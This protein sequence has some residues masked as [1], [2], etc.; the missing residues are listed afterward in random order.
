MFAQ[1]SD[2]FDDGDFTHNPVW[3]GTNTL[4]TVTAG[5]L[6]LSA[7][8][9]SDMAYLSTQSAAL[10]DATWEA[11]VWL[12]FNASATNY[13]RFYLAS[14]QPT[15][16]AA[17]T[18]YFVQIGGATDDV[19]LFRQEGLTLE[20]LIDGADGRL[21]LASVHVKIKVTRDDSGVWQLFSDVNNG[22]LTLEGTKTDVTTLTSNYTGLSCTFTATRSDKFAFDNFRVTGHAVTDKT[23]PALSSIMVLSSTRLAVLFSE[24]LEQASAENTA[25]Y[26]VGSNS[27]APVSATLLADQKTVELLFANAFVNGVATTLGVQGVRDLAGNAMA[28]AVRDFTYLAPA[29]ATFKDLLI[30]EIF[31][32]PS[33]KIRLPEAEYVEV[34][35]RS[36]TPFSLKNWRLTDGSTAATL[37]EFILLPGDFAVLTSA[38]TGFTEVHNALFI[39]NFPTLNNGSDFVVLKDERGVTIDS[40][41]YLADWFGDADKQ[42]GGWALEIIDPENLCGGAKNWTASDDPSGGTPGRQNSVFASKPDL[43]APVLRAA[44]P[45]SATEIVLTFDETL[46]KVLPDLSSFSIDPA[47]TFRQLSFGDVSLTSLRLSLQ[48]PL[49]PSTRYALTLSDIEDCSGNR[50]NVAT[51]S[52]GLPQ[53]ADSLD[54]V[55]NELLFNPR[56]TGVDFL[57]I[58]NT[59]THYLNLKNWSLATEEDD[60]AQKA[61]VIAPDDFLVA[62]GAYVVL[63]VDGDL[64]KGEY[65]LSREEN[66]LEVTALPSWADDAGSVVLMNAEGQIVDQFSYTKEMHSVFVKDDEGVSLER[67]SMQQPTNAIENWK[68]AS[69][70]VGFAT[71]GYLNSNAPPARQATGEAIDVLPQVFVPLQGQP[72]FTQIHYA[73]DRGGYVANVKV[74]DAQGR[75]VKVIAHNTTLGT[76][77]SFRWDGDRDEG[78]KARMGAYM[79]WFEVFDA[80]GHLK[81]FRKTVVVAAQF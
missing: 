16:S 32:D 78:D 36:G 11:D 23:P 33:P 61:K 65:P 71:P 37:P 63:T 56:P 62:P 57:E 29:T 3:T 5:Q 24:S 10:E 81:V 60:N 75:Q 77:G 15:L 20:K 40:V 30:S 50:M 64:L 73:F 58:V 51:V 17:L 19:S 18:G 4:F 27:M 41:R 25:N 74:I 1:A 42:Q 52:F 48:T 38:S 28:V 35:N 7:P 70:T 9:V 31:A 22:G 12:D 46:N 80:E 59:S 68:S 69:A 67:I 49:Q 44:I 34:Y 6:K 76:E 14:N 55:I 13:A 21:N 43:T 53:T 2:A 45:T 54:V 72:D 79:I 66:F 39:A 8:A 26:A 47:Q